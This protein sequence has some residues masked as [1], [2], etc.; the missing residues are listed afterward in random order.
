[1]QPN[2][3]LRLQLRGKAEFLHSNW[4]RWKKDES[5]PLW[6][7]VKWR[8]GNESFKQAISLCAFSS[9]CVPSLLTLVSSSLSAL[10][11]YAGAAEAAD[12]ALILA[13]HYIPALLA[14]AE[15]KL[16]QVS[17]TQDNNQ[18]SKQ[19]NNQH[20]KNSPS[21]KKEFTGYIFDVSTISKCC[22]AL[23]MVA[24]ENKM[25]SKTWVEFP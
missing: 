16:K 12:S 3:L 5:Q 19:D 13:P 9:P 17:F 11:D 4:F 21:F 22:R 6:L 25:K 14:S 23:W 1:M 18:H 2:T 8:Y 10:N 15:I 20:S 7:S 24:E